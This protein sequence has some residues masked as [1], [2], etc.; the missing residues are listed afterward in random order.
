MAHY[1]LINHA[2]RFIVCVDPKCGSTTVKD[3][4]NQSLPRPLAKFNRD[5]H[6][7]MI[8][9]ERVPLYQ[10]YLKIFVIREPLRRLV[11]F[12]LQWVVCDQERWCFADQAQQVSLRNHTF[13]EFLC[14]L[15]ALAGQG[16]PYQ[17]HLKP[18]TRILADVH[19]DQVVK[20]ETTHEQFAGINEQLGLDY[21]PD[22]LNAQRYSQVSRPGAFDVAPSLLR[23]EP[24]HP[25]ESFY[26]QT[27]KALA[28]KLYA[29]DVQ[30][31]AA[32]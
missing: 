29:T 22:R 11:S 6:R 21:L 23:G 7:F 2:K 26:N 9:A 18:Q 12:Y 25:Y 27:L 30:F 17:H 4:F 24:L 13:R 31:Y 20:L 1:C 10:D 3:W 19:F 8:Q 32:H 15:E 16:A 5:I 28:M 14:T